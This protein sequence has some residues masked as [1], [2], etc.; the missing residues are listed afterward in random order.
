MK[1]LF[2]I[3]MWLLISVA[4]N[5]VTFDKV[6]ID[7]NLNA[8]HGDWSGDVYSDNP[9]RQLDAFAT[10]VLDHQV[11]WYSNDG[12][13]YTW[14]PKNV[15]YTA[16]RNIYEVSAEDLNGDGWVDA[17]ASCVRSD[18]VAYSYLTVLINNQDGTFTA[19]PLDTVMARL[20]QTRLADVNGD[21]RI[22]IIVAGSA[23]RPQWIQE[24]G[25]Y[26]YRNNVGLTFTKNFIATCDAWKVDIFDDEPDGHLEIVV[27]EEFF[28]QDSASP[29]RIIMYKNNGAEGF[30]PIIIDPNVGLNLGDPP[31]GG[32]VRCVKLDGDNRTDIIG[33]SSY[34]GALYWY[35]N[36]G[37]NSFTK[38]T[39][40]GMANNIDG[41]DIGDF[42]TDHDVDIVAC[43]RNYWIAWYEN[44]GNGN[45]T[46]NTF[47]TE[48]RVFDLPYVTY[49]D[50]DTCPDILVTETSYPTGHLIAYLNP[51]PGKVEEDRNVPVGNWIKASSIIGKG[52]VDIAFGIQNTGKVT[53]E[54]FDITGKLVDIV[55]SYNYSRSGAYSTKWNTNNIPNGVYLLLLKSE[56]QS[57]IAKKVT[58]IR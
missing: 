26:W 9:S 24:A 38:N 20:R 22:D 5:A 29:A 44:D 32:G 46:R 45:F 51:C 8:P 52:F 57:V 42:D 18:S 1:K 7:S 6:V 28:G 56:G 54:A 19:M 37:G 39:I 17:V 40:D 23:P 35:K 50:G 58:L 4:L 12:A 53:I 47:D 21:G 33:S 11:V 3:G 43:G 25:V 10:I 2:L 27:A 31:G 14:G 41:I 55:M 16:D 13:G 48:W 30:N 36:N 49:F 34:L 15:I